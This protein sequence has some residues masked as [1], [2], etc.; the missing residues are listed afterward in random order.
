[1][2]LSGREKNQRKRTASKR[3]EILK[4]EHFKYSLEWFP[5]SPRLL[6][7][8]S[9]GVA[10]EIESHSRVFFARNMTFVYIMQPYVGSEACSL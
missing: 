2:R 6:V 9:A 3:S 7:L 10:V 1:M 5:L 4:R 8:G